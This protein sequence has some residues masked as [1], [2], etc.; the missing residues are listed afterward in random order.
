MDRSQEVAVG[1]TL[2]ERHFSTPAEARAE[3]AARGWHAAEYDVPAEENEL[4]WHD[5][6]SV[7]FVLEGTSRTVFADGRVME[8]GSGARIESPAGVPHRAASPAYRAVFGFPVPPDSM[9][10]PINKPMT[11]WRDAPPV[12]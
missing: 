6:D 2:T 10:L 4:H 8:C 7:A 12:A 11:E 1:F 9:S 3:I 5:F